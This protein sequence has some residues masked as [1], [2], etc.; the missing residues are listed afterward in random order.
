MIQP[1]QSMI[2][3][4]HLKTNYLIDKKKMNEKMRNYDSYMNEIVTSK[5]LCFI[6]LLL[7]VRGDASEVDVQY[8]AQENGNTW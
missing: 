1:I 3:A 2:V 4:E 5:V 6:Y 8:F 7:L